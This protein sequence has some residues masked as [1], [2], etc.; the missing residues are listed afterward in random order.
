MAIQELVFPADFPLILFDYRIPER[1]HEIHWHDCL[2][3]GLI[4]SGRGAFHIEGKKFPFEPGDLF[5]V[6]RLEGHRAHALPGTSA[7]ARFLYIGDRFLE[8]L[9]PLTGGLDLWRL[10]SLGGPG[11]QNRFQDPAVAEVLRE[12]LAESGRDGALPKAMTRTAVLRLLLL[13]LRRFES[14]LP[15]GGP[16]RFTERL[17]RLLDFIQSHLN[18]D[19]AAGSLSDYCGLS[20]A[21]FRKRFKEVLGRSPREW[22]EER[23]LFHARR[24][25]EAA[26]KGPREAARAAGFGDY[27]GFQRRY[28]ARF[29]E[30]PSH[31]P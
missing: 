5:L 12:A 6:N 3:V 15:A 8:S 17:P 10:F 9:A 21:H 4:E 31:R 26:G 18:E 19:L 25:I 14:V 22:V 16:D 20:E 28:K 7:T 30:N 11:F 13:L 29:G 24:L 23:R 1:F 27:S 2:E